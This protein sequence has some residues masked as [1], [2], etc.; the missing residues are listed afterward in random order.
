M[1]DDAILTAATMFDIDWHAGVYNIQS[2]TSF[3]PRY[4]DYLVGHSLPNY[5]PYAM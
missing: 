2:H 5:V 1:E 3:A 4:S